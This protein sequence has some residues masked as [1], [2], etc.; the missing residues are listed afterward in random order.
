MSFARAAIVGT[1]IWVGIITLLH[2]FLNHGGSF[3]GS[4]AAFN[5]GFLPVT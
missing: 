5:V 2:F 3:G 4:R 1:L